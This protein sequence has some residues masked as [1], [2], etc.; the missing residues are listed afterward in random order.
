VKD[1]AGHNS[2]YYTN[3]IR[4]LTFSGGNMVIE[5][6]DG[7]SSSYSISSIRKLDFSG[8]STDILIPQQRLQ[9]E[10]ATKIY[11]NP[12]IDLLYIKSSLA[13][14]CEVIVE[15]LDL[16]GKV[17]LIE[18]ISDMN[19]INVSDLQKGIYIC[20]VHICDKIENIKFLK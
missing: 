12:V 7:S 9:N 10:E 11:P 3:D 1:N 8:A 19:G 4:K 5:K 14:E 2:S 13:E 20:R 18:K 15:V 16:Q 6:T 17:L